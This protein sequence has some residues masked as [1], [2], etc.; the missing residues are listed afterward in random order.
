MDVSA[1]EG[2]PLYPSS[3]SQVFE[4]NN[5]GTSHPVG[6]PLPH[7]A[8]TKHTTGEAVYTDDIP[9]YK[10]ELVNDVNLTLGL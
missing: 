5:D 2:P 7:L 4:V 6:R 1:T 9:P 10:G 3:G 8:G